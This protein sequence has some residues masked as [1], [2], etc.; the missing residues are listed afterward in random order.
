MNMLARPAPLLAA[1]IF[2]TPL[3]ASAAFAQ[4]AAEP[5]SAPKLQ[6]P[7]P[8]TFDHQ[9]MLLKLTIPDVTDPMFTATMTLTASALADDTSTLMLDAMPTLAIGTVTVDGVPATFTHSDNKLTITLPSAARAG[10]THNFTISYTATKPF[11]AGSG[12]VFLKGRVPREGSTRPA[13]TPLIFSQGEANWNRYW[14]P[15][16]D[17]PEEK[18]STELIVDVPGDQT[19]ISN[20]RLLELRRGERDGKPRA[21]WHWL[22]AKRHAPY[23]VML[24]VGTFDIVNVGHTS[25]ARG[26]VGPNGQPIEQWISMPIYG[27]PGSGKNLGDTFANTASMV[28][29][30]SILLDQP[31]PWDKYAQ[32]IV[33]GF[34]WG[35]MENT[36]A[37]VLAEFAASGAR[38]SKDELIV[39]ELVHQWFGDLVTCKSW[40]HLWLNEGWATYSEN[41]WIEKTSGHDDYLKRMNNI[42]QR[43]TGG[44]NPRAPQQTAMVS[45]NVG[46]PDAE[47]T[48]ADNPY[49]KGGF[50]LH[51]L[52]MR[53]GD[54][55]FFTGVREYLK[56]HAL[57]SVVTDDFRHSLELASGKDLTGY[58]DQWMTRPGFAKLDI[59]WSTGSSPS[60]LVL[61]I[62]QVQQIDSDNPAYA[63]DLPIVVKS[64][65]GNVLSRFTVSFNQTEHRFVGQQPGPIGRISVDPEATVLAN[66]RVKKADEKAAEPKP[67]LNSKPDPN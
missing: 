32:V 18:L 25:T 48:K 61:D 15:C 19:V 12:L 9:H 66:L 33:R 34:R 35:G 1:V 8:R 14:F 22:Q 43:I 45:P 29:H 53:L 23:L 13:A 11:E 20:G 10:R 31:Y 26:I 50:L 6:T 38:G 57:T 58:F 21:I 55:A 67:E 41:L 54:E 46:D 7:T 44:R 39:H 2:L 42:R 62:K 64:E 16:H 37:T 27:P 52:R 56:K 65:S 17:W 5:D 36:S 3:W 24:A 40:N 51:T 47:F 59:N 4:D 49:S 63:I 28:D 30:F 60:E